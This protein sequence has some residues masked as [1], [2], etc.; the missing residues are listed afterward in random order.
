MLRRIGEVDYKIDIA[1]AEVQRDEATEAL[2][3]EVASCDQ[4]R[5]E[6]SVS[7]AQYDE[8]KTP[9][10]SMPAERLDIKKVLET[11]TGLENKIETTHTNIIELK[12]EN[13]EFDSKLKEYDDFLTTIDIEE[14]L[15]QKREYDEVKKKYDGYGYLERVPLKGIRKTISENMIKSTS[16]SAPATLMEDIDV[17]NMFKL[18]KTEQKHFAIEGIKLDFL[19]FAIKAVISSLK[20]NPIANSSIEGDEIIIKKYFNIGIAVETEVGLM[21]PVIKIANKK[22][23]SKLAKEIQEL[24]EK[25]KTRKIDV[26]DLS[27]GTFTINYYGQ[28]GGTY[29]ALILNPSEAGIL[30]M[31]K[32]YDKVI[33]KNGKIKTMKALPVS[34]TFDHRSLDGAQAARVLES[35]KRLLDDPEHWF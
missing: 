21:V 25:A 7:E 9:I 23:I 20:E 22:S 14:L 24:T 6:L 10:D 28:V 3:Q 31:G 35:L 30:G 16:E 18:I 32:S 17:S 26:M 15:S 19:P 2:E 11:R 33:S 8:L 12:Q 27:G 4:M 29:G 5:Q 1:V 13:E 34:I